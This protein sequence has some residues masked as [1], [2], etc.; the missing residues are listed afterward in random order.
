MVVEAG[1]QSSWWPWP[2]RGSPLS[3][4]CGRCPLFAFKKVVNLAEQSCFLG[5]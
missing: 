1:Q 5:D 4:G 2:G 3:P